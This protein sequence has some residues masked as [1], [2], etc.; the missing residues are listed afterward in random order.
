MTQE[1]GVRAEFQKLA[2]NVSALTVGVDY[3]F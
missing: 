3:K 2:S 1:A